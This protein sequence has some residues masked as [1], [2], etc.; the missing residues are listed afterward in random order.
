M[1]TNVEARIKIKGKNFEILV[2]LDKA[3]QLRKGINVSIENILAI[4][5]IFYDVKKGLKV[6][7]ADLQNYFSTDNVREAAKKIILEGEIQLPS[8]Y[9]AKMVDEKMKQIIDFIA[10]NAIDPTTNKPHSL[11]RIEDAIK[12]IGIKIDNKPVQEQI[13]RVLEELRKILPLRIE[14]KKIKLRIPAIYTGQVYNLI[15]E[16]KEK[17]EWLNNGDLEV[18]V[19]I[20]A[21]L[22]IEFYDKINHVCHGNVI[23]QEIKE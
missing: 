21:G 8:E 1:A 13:P 3:L 7:K 22:Q 15:K 17:E 6:S 5:E 2:D 11:T 19:N 18:I 14:T 10:R 9:K 4:D 20:P 12:K 16:Y 23:S